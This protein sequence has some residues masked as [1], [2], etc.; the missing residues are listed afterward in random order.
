MEF[1]TVR[2]LRTSFPKIEKILASGEA[3][4]I[5]KRNKV[6]GVLTPPPEKRKIKMPDF[7][8]RMRKIF[9]DM[10]NR[11]MVEALIAE[12]NER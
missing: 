12:R 6:L 11:G 4:E 1:V 5:R 8:A 10:E 7:E 2:D 3:V 9:P